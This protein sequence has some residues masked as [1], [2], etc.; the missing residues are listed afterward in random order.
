[1]TDDRRLTTDRFYGGTSQR[2][3]LLQEFLAFLED[4]ETKRSEAKDWILENTRASSRDAIDHHFGFLNAIELIDLDGNAVSIDWRGKQYLESPESSVLYSALR[5]NV[6]GF[7][8]ILTQL[9]EGPMTD[10]DI[11]RHLKNKFEDINMDSPGVATRH[12][13][14]LQVLGYLERSRGSNFL[15][16]KGGEV[17][18]GGM[19]DHDRVQQLRRRLLETEMPCVPT[20][21]QDLTEDIYPAVK[22]EYSDLCDDSYRCEDAHENGRDQPEWQHAVRDIQQ[23]IA[24]R[25]EGRIHRHDEVG[26]WLYLPRNSRT[27]QEG[28]EASHKGTST[29]DSSQQTDDESGVSESVTELPG[30]SETTQRREA[31]REEVV[32]DEALVNDIKSMYDDRCQICGEKRL[33][34]PEK[35]YSEVHHLM[36]LGDDGPDIPE[37]VVVLCPNHHIDFESG[38]LSIDP[39]TFE[40]SHRYDHDVDGR[41]LLLKDGHE[42]GGGYINYHNQVVAHPEAE[43]GR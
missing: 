40:I 43:S 15:T 22:R 25:E 32:R 24:D 12:R 28:E 14:W 18:T 30:G 34:G 31:V 35:G 3:Q 7:D 26:K 36:P 41:E 17:T 38:M 19:T 20:G 39:E 27:E 5:E 2:L 9:Q 33:Q 6:K 29:D 37:N 21:Q 42:V 23:R 13:E 4:G 10:E 11:M 1:M 16:E 8:S